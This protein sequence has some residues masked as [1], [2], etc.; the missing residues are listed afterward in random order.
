[1]AKTWR[2]RCI[3]FSSLSWPSFRSSACAAPCHAGKAARMRA[4]AAGRPATSRERKTD[5]GDVQLEGLT[6]H[7]HL[8]DLAKQLGLTFE[9][10][11]D[12]FDIANN[13]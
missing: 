4:H 3:C 2:F 12:F 8:L 6:G 9:N 7:L 10:R 5:D 13:S 1:M 11:C